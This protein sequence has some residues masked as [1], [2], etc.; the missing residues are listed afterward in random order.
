MQRPRPSQRATARIYPPTLSLP[1][2]KGK[3]RLSNYLERDGDLAEIEI[4]D[5][6][7]S[8]LESSADGD[9]HSA[10]LAMARRASFGG[11]E[12]PPVAM[13][14][15]IFGTGYAGL[16]TSVCLAQLG[17]VVTAVDKDAEIV[18]ALSQGTPTIREPG[19]PELLAATLDAGRLHF[20]TRPEDAIAASAIIFVCVGTPPRNDGRADLAQV[21]E[22]ARTIAPLLD[23]YKLVVEK[24]TVPA[25]TAR[26]I[27]WTIRRLAGPEAE[28]DVA[29]NPEFLREG[30]AVRDFLQPDRIVIG[31][32]SERAR[33]LL[34]DL[35]EPSFD[36]SEEHTSE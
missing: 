27:S 26:W 32:D 25:R 10:D 13:R 36:R 7:V 23:G 16:V 24:S 19:L 4:D 35:Y 29:S 15:G 28:F 14:L 1:S 3:S 21:E 8:S 31:A 20:T 2:W 18:A 33:S 5:A 34:L 12:P 17:H 22:V 30:S 6:D 11:F 9:G